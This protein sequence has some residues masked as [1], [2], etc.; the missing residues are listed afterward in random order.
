MFDSTSLLV[1]I[2]ASLGLLIIPGPAVFY[3]VARSVEQGRVAGLVSTL[4]I[5]L[6]SV[7]HVALAALGLSA[8]IFNSALLFSF[9]KYLG[10]AYLI[11]LGIKTLLQTERPSKQFDVKQ[12]K[13]STLF[14]QGFIVNLL[15]PKTALFFLAFLPQ[16]VS[17]ENG[18]VA[19]Q[20]VILGMIFVVLAI[21][22][23]GLYAILAGSIAPHLSA[24]HKPLAR[25]QTYFSGFIYIALGI[26]TALFSFNKS[27]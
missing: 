23:D 2:A 11:Y 3:I 19:L 4:G 21:F 10:A 16:F 26:S 14:W 1:F 27:K 7:L 24:G 20:F 6:A 18:S 5:T 12:S 25:F 15:N 13:L 17:P 22:S 8:V 9:I